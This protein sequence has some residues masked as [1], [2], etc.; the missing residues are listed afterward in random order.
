VKPSRRCRIAVGFD[1]DA[2]KRFIRDATETH[3]M[4]QGFGD[5]GIPGWVVQANAPVAVPT[6]SPARIE[7]NQ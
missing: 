3:L 1:E 7:L 5:Y 2:R 6:A 4:A